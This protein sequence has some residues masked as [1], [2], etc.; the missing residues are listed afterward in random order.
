MLNHHCQISRSEMAFMKESSEESLTS[1]VFS[2]LT[3][4][5]FVLQIHN[6]CQNNNLTIN[7][8]LK[9]NYEQEISIS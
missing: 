2:A 1:I 3:F 7:K 4:N 6:L 9:G 8:Q 5:C